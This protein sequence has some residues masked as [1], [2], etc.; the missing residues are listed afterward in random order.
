MR[1]EGGEEAEKEAPVSVPGAPDT[2]HPPSD[3]REDT[4][5]MLLFSDF[6][7]GHF[8]CLGMYSLKHLNKIKAII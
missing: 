8:G 3:V 7:E 2:G 1:V 4:P 6:Q 5:K